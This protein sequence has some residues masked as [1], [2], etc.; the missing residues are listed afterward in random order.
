MDNEPVA[1]SFRTLIENCL[2]Q[3]ALPEQ[4]SPLPEVKASGVRTEVN[5]EVL[6]NF[7]KN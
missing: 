4:T 3:G 5:V 6:R 1:V 7:L 2:K